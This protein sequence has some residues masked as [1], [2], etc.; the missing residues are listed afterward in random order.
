MYWCLIWLMSL[1]TLTLFL[2]C[3]AK[4]K[5]TLVILVIPYFQHRSHFPGDPVVKTVLPMQGVWV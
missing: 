1:K 3:S 4:G 2:P 5:H